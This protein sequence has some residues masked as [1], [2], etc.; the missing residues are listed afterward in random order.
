[1]S[2][3]E[4]YQDPYPTSYVMQETW[5]GGSSS[6][7][8]I[9]ER[10]K[11]LFQSRH[12]TNTPKALQERT[13][14]PFVN[15]R[16]YEF[17]NTTKVVRRRLLVPV[18]IHPTYMTT[19]RAPRHPPKEYK[20]KPGQ[21]VTKRGAS[22]KTFRPQRRVDKSKL[23]VVNRW[24]YFNVPL[25]TR[26]L[27]PVRYPHHS[28]SKRAKKTK[29]FPSPN[30]FTFYKVG[31]SKVSNDAV[32]GTNPAI[33]G[34]THKIEYQASVASW[35]ASFGATV[36]GPD[37]SRFSGGTLWGSSAHDELVEKSLGKLRDKIKNQKV[38]LANVAVEAHKSVDMIGKLATRLFQVCL[39]AKRGNLVKAAKLIFPTTQKEMANEWLLFQ[40]G[41]LPLIND[42]NGALD[43]L[44]N[45]HSKVKMKKYVSTATIDVANLETFSSVWGVAVT[46]R[47]KTTGKLVVKH[48]CEA[49]ITDELLEDLNRLGISNLTT[50]AWEAIPFSFVVDW[51]LPIGNWLNRLDSLQG[52]NV[53]NISRT[54]FYKIRYVGTRNFGG[55]TNDG[56]TWDNVSCSWTKEI[57]R[58]ERQLLASV[59]GMTFPTF[60]SPF[61]SMHVANALALLV[62][63]R[64]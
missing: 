52:W 11:D 37:E 49:S 5:T 62:Q 50:G 27:V 15:R 46:G 3:G 38:N 59:P 51:F 44:K 19:P 20:L 40:Y 26:R 2:Y 56:W 16:E 14:P 22:F 4:I 34:W 39:A 42:I 41:I 54:S 25:V 60:K 8:V 29:V 7:Y 23:I 10:G 48:R 57:I 18:Y 33:P 63:L 30:A 35:P 9:Y 61:S 43:E 12:G 24:Y 58:C 47:V 45:Y 1:M 53:T 6:P 36:P 31:L 13:K 21:T 28:S 32:K 17:V 55:T 64:K